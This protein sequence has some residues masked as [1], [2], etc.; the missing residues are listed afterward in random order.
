MRHLYR[1]AFILTLILMAACE[2]EPVPL[3]TRFPTNTPTLSPTPTSTSTPTP[4]PTITPQPR[5]Q[6]RASNPAD[7]SYLRLVHGIPN[8]PPVTLMVDSVALAYNLSFTQFTG[9]TEILAGDYA[10]SITIGGV[11]E[12][13]QLII[14][15]SLMVQASQTLFLILNGTVESP[16]LDVHVQNEAPLASGESSVALIHAV[17]NGPEIRFQVGEQDLTDTVAFSE[18]TPTVALPSGPTTFSV[19]SD[20][21]SLLGHITELREHFNYTYVALGNPDDTSTYT[22]LE[23]SNRVQGFATMRV[24]N[25]LTGVSAIDFY[26][27]GTRLEGPIDY[28]R[29]TERGQIL[30]GFYNIEVFEAGVDQSTSAPLA[31][32]ELNL[33]TGDNISFIS[34]GS[35]EDARLVRFEDNLSPVAPDQLRIVFANTLDFPPLVRVIEGET[36][37]PG[38][39][40]LRAQQVSTDVLLDAGIRDFHWRIVHSSGRLG[41]S[42]EVAPNVELSPGRSYLFLMTGRGSDDPPII[43]SEVVD[44]EES[45]RISEE[46][47]P[48]TP[49]EPV[50][51]R[52]ANTLVEN[53][54]VDFLVDGITVAD[55]L[56]YGE[57]TDP[58]IVPEGVHTMSIRRPGDS[59][60]LTLLDYDFQPG[61]NFSLYIYGP[62]ADLGEILMLVNLSLAEDQPVSLV[63]FINVTPDTGIQFDLGI[64]EADQQIIVPTP[65]QQGDEP[66]TVPFREPL[67]V[68]VAK[69]AVDLGGGVGSPSAYAESRP[70]DFYVIDTARDLVAARLDDYLLEPG[71]H[72][73]IVAFQ[74]PASLEVRTIVLPYRQSTRP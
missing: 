35:A 24:I 51:I 68:G 18:R 16:S 3:P 31:S 66:N 27:N 64:A 73:D 72:Y 45:L 71:I 74:V 17:P 47:T 34:M 63:R 32:M 41:D 48:P 33:N 11:E 30:T 65:N 15:Q 26:A 39:P 43:F 4:L 22:L 28:T 58:I 29:S 14:Q 38:L 19:A 55:S 59:I 62:R 67:F 36:S 53:T 52:V 2:R 10:A 13:Q 23:F 54:P 61:S 12:D 70:V 69:I 7:Q 21:Q 46:V 6:T 37:V 20:E 25:A 5:L 49:S 50:K 60:D 56:G 44:I 42:V 1:L 8:L 9:P 57:I 40:E